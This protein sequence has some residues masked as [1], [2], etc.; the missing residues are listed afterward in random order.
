MGIA[1]S[2]VPA[3]GPLDGVLLGKWT[4][5]SFR[6]TATPNIPF[7]DLKFGEG[8]LSIDSLSNGVMNGSLDF[9]PDAKVALTGSISYGNP[10][11]LQ[12]QGKGTSS[13]NADWLYDYTGYL[14][15]HWPQGK[16]QRAA[17]V[18]TIVRSLPHS[19]GAAPAGVVS[20]W[21]AVR[22]DSIK[23]VAGAESLTPLLDPTRQRWEEFLKGGA[24]KPKQVRSRKSAERKAALPSMA[25]SGLESMFN[26]ASLPPPQRR[27]LAMATQEPFLQ[28]DVIQSANGVLRATFEVVMGSGRIGNDPVSLRNYSATDEIKGLKFGA[29]LVGPTLRVRPGDTMLITLVNSLAVEPPDGNLNQLRQ[30]NTTNLHFH[31][32]HVSPSGN[33]DNVLLEV[34]PQTTQQYEVQ[35][36]KDHPCGTYWYHAHHHGSVAA[37]V[38]SGMAGA[39]IIEGG[40]DQVPQI[41][42]AREQTLVLQQVPY[43]N[44]NLSVGVIENNPAFVGKLFGP[45]DWDLLG[46]FTTI[47]GLQLPVIQMQPGELVR[48]RIVN[49]GFREPILLHLAKTDPSAA[50][51]DFI[52]FNEI[53]VDGLPLGKLQNQSQIELW[54]GYRSEVLIQAPSTPGNYLLMDERLPTAPNSPPDARKYLARI[55]ITGVPLTMALPDSA[56]LQG[57][58]L[59][60]VKDQEVTGQQSA[61]Y[62]IFPKTGGGVQFN[63][64]GNS[65]SMDMDKSRK[66]KLGDVDEWTLT[67]KNGV[68]PV[69]HPFHIHVNPFEIVSILDETGAEQLD[70]PI[71]RDTIILNDGWKVRM[72]TRYQDFDGAFVQ[73]CHIL[74]HEDQGMMQNVVIVDPQKAAKLDLPAGRIVPVPGAPPQ[75]LPTVLRDFANQPLMLAVIRSISCGSCREQISALAKAAG[76]GGWPRILVVAPDSA[77]RVAAFQKDRSLPFQIISDPTRCVIKQYA[78]NA[79]AD[80]HAVFLTDAQGRLRWQQT[81]EE[82][83]LAFDALK[84]ELPSLAPQPSAVSMRAAVP[85]TGLESLPQPAASIEIQVRNTPDLSDDYLTWA[86]TP[87]RIRLVTSTPGSAS[88]PAILTNDIPQ[89]GPVPPDGDLAFAE[90][91]APG[92]TATSKQ[93]PVLLP[94]SGEWVNFVMAGDFPRASSNDKDAVVEVHG[95]SPNG[96]LLGQHGVMVRIRKDHR[97]LSPGERQRFLQA[98]DYLQRTAVD[99]NGDSRYMYY[100]KLHRAA[101]WGLRFG[102]TGGPNY[103]W[104]DLAHKAPGFIAWHR[105]F[106][107]EFEREIQKTFPSVSLPYWIMNEPSVLFTEDFMGANDALPPPNQSQAA[108][109]ASSN[110]LFGWT[111]DIDGANNQPVQ[112][113]TTGRDP[114]GP[115][116]RPA[117]AFLSDAQ[118]LANPQF[119]TYPQVGPSGGFA[120]I[121]EDNPHNQ[122]HNWTGRWMQNCATSPRDPIFWVFHAGFD[123]QWAAWQTKYG[124]FNPSGANG[125]FCPSGTFD[126]PG[127]VCGNASGPADC[128]NISSLNACVPITH[129]LNDQFWPWSGKFGQ[130]ASKNG[131][132]PQQDLA[133]PFLAP[134][135]PS[136]WAGLWPSAPAQ[137]TPADMI[138]YLGVQG[139]DPLGFAYD[140]SPYPSTAQPGPALAA[141]VANAQALDSFSDPNLPAAQ[142]VV[143]LESISPRRKLQPA[144]MDKLVKAV[145][146]GK[147]HQSVRSSALHAVNAADPVR[148]SEESMQLIKR[149]TEADHTAAQG[150][151]VLSA[152][153]MSAVLTDST[154]TKIMSTLED[155]LQAPSPHVRSAALSSLS[156]MGPSEMVEK[157]AVEALRNPKG[158]AHAPAEAINSLMEMQAA[159]KNAADI[160]PFLKSNDVAARTEAVLA[161]AMDQ[162]SWENITTILL[163]ARQP[164]SVRSSAIHSVL[165]SGSDA[166]GPLLKLAQDSKT[167]GPLRAESVA[168]IG[169]LVRSTKVKLSKENLSQ[170]VA[171]LS[172]IPPLE[173][174]QLGPILGQTLLR[175]NHRLK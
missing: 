110:P 87:C 59:P 33:S 130:A 127:P 100:V 137:P 99:A 166:I 4:Y 82:P 123:R 95:G 112:R 71:W 3:A 51:P 36:P 70:A 2:L 7:N 98:L 58:R 94:A 9:G 73:H 144:D 156:S 115:F 13:Q 145:R 142:R 18:G 129:H 21:I 161:L 151:E 40:Q 155:A 106:L 117:R 57:F 46:R 24:E 53:A 90:S 23:A 125:S 171:S 124:K 72:R 162:P 68:G 55:V 20:S 158:A 96:P 44:K 128:N 150:V 111:A 45:G 15:Y 75:P 52:P 62:G 8:E 131:S 119:S 102:N 35:I 167:D 101:A 6:N 27:A 25:P 147:E 84:A 164:K 139:R 175:A 89:T 66:L 148:G 65:Y 26:E 92:T 165:G 69:N 30:F 122:G 146:D 173:A 116:W 56:Q 103:Y 41:T 132:L 134:F 22:Q 108:K 16:D 34:L 133:Q 37:Q 169:V 91:V 48:W 60:S 105:T 121:V 10:P 157:A 31:G 83:L 14:A 67:S 140:D 78:P 141:S 63:I 93:L 113:F 76:N 88:V 97:K 17:I 47:N 118:V 143:A 42:A 79:P 138:D 19:G 28:P 159:V 50:G 160:R 77:E 85:S 135:A 54:P 86:P 136:A 74:D 11:T 152:N 170:I 12:F 39:I 81:G 154:R 80:S 61:S 174:D 107:L 29:K 64:D 153:L 43:W 149:N 32:L 163:D 168:G 120:E 1:Q 5:R 49:S 38:A 109:F 104:P 126:A 172:A 114:N